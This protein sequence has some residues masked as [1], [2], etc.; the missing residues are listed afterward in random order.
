MSWGMAKFFCIVK[1]ERNL[2]LLREIWKKKG[3]TAMAGHW[4][5]EEEK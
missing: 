2:K 3:L 4:V 5:A 1:G